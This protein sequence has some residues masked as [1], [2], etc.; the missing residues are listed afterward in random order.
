MFFVALRCNGIVDG[1]C[2]A[3]TPCDVGDGDCDWERGNDECVGGLVCGVDNC[4]PRWEFGLDC[5]MKGKFLI[6]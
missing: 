6:S 3:T 2:T 1:C 5:C 4:D